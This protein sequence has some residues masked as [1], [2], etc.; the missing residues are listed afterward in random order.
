M[1]TDVHTSRTTTIKLR[2]ETVQAGEALDEA[3]S[4]GYPAFL[5]TPVGLALPT[6]YVTIGDYDYERPSTYSHVR[7]WSVDVVEVA[8]PPPSIYGPPST[9][10]DIIAAY[11]TW[12]D[13][14]AAFP[15]WRD[16]MGD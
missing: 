9:W 10:A 14:L 11:P 2:T 4:A 1:V 16:V 6:M 12:G 5:H 3:L 15:T 7:R 13:V 8:P